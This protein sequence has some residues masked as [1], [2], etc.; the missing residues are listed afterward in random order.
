[1]ASS[2]RLAGGEPGDD[3]DRRDGDETAGAGDGVVDPGRDAGEMAV[4]EPNAVVVSGAT[5]NV[6]ADARTRACR[7]APLRSSSPGLD[8]REQGEPDGA[9]QRPDGHREPRADALGERPAR[10]EN[11]SIMTVSG[12]VAA[13]ASSGE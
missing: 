11:S 9:Q 13:P 1:M 3:R 6:E 2:T 8:A 4:T 5:V 10:A 7:A 12:N